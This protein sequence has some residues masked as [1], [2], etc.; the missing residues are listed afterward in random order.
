MC[1]FLI[2]HSP[3]FALTSL[4]FRYEHRLQGVFQL[5][6]ACEMLDIYWVVVALSVF[7]DFATSQKMT[8][9]WQ[10]L[11]SRPKLKPVT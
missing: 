2:T 4:S 6:P 9:E 8:G 7:S 11:W 3:L 1:V 10:A 5:H